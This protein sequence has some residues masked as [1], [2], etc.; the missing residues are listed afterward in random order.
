[1]VR[2][3]RSKGIL[4][5][6]YRGRTSYGAFPHYLP[7]LGIGL[8]RGPTPGIIYGI[9]RNASAIAHEVGHALAPKWVFNPST[10]ARSQ[11]AARLGTLFGSL[12][13]LFSR[14]ETNSRNAAL[15]GTAAN[16][17]LLA[18]ETDASIRGANILKRLGARSRI[19]AFIGLPTYAL[20]AGIPLGAHYIKKLLG[21][22]EHNKTV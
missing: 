14:D 22:F 9:D 10:I 21:G 15:A 20:T 3:A 5:N 8:R 1:L 12:G 19:G 11:Q 13:A 2:F 18:L 16:L 6:A 7:D 17:P 4:M